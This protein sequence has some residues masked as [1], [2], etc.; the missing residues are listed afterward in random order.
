MKT[1]ATASGSGHAMF[2]GTSLEYVDRVMVL[3]I[4]TEEM[5]IETVLDAPIA[6][7]LTMMA[8]E[9]DGKRTCISEGLARSP[10]Q[11]VISKRFAQFLFAFSSFVSLK[12]ARSKWSE[13]E[14]RSFQRS[15]L[16]ATLRC[17]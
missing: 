1:T 9:R 4:N 5:Q 11:E 7:A 16:Y 10:N 17:C 6:K 14:C 13:K 2:S 12:R 15:L 8:A 3:R